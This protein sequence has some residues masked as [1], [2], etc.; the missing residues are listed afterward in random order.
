MQ[1]FDSFDEPYASESGTTPHGPIPS[2]DAESI[3]V[4]ASNHFE[5]RMMMRDVDSFDEP[6]AS[7]SGTTP[8]G[9][10]P[11]RDA[12]SIHVEASNHFEGRMMMRDVDSFEEPYAP[13]HRTIPPEPKQATTQPMVSF[14]CVV[15][16]PRGYRVV[17]HGLTQFLYDI[18]GLSLSQETGKKTLQVE[19]YGQIEV[20]LYTLALRGC[21]SIATNID[22]QPEQQQHIGCVGN[23]TPTIQF[24]FT[25]TIAISTAVK[26]SVKPLP[27]T[28]IDHR[29]I[30][31]E[32]IQLEPLDATNSRLWKLTG[33]FTFRV[34]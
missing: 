25:D 1:D 11:S 30:K 8:H 17:S 9:P 5:G 3:H 24:Y 22:I 19:E 7:E 23:H 14:Q 15:E 21:I 33:V 32:Q 29:H 13:E 10:I 34:E 12:E 26:H 2:R 20:E 31:V 27:H 6:Y 4:E 16:T 28:T 18:S